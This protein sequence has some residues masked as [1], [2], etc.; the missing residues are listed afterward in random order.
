MTGWCTSAGRGPCAPL[1]PR[2]QRDFTL[3][4]AAAQTEPAIAAALVDRSVRTRLDHY[5]ASGFRT[6]DQALLDAGRRSGGVW[7]TSKDFMHF[8]I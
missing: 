5:A 8:E 7:S 2:L 6:F 1:S 3:T 4:W